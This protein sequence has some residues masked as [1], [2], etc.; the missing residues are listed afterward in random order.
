MT[1]SALT[2]M[3]GGGF[4]NRNSSLQE[5]AILE[6]L[7]LWRALVA[8]AP[9]KDDAFVIVDY[10]ASQGKNSLRPI[11]L[12]IDV[13]RNR[14]ESPKAIEVIHTDLPANDF[15][16]LFETLINDPD[17]YLRKGADIYP[18]A[19]GRSYFEPILAPDSAH[20]A[21]NSWSLQWTSVR[22]AEIRDHIFI[23]GSADAVARRA[24]ED[25]LAQDW[26]AFLQARAKELAPGG[27]LLTMFVAKDPSGAGW[28]PFWD[29]LW[30]VLQ[31][32]AGEGLL[33]SDV[34]AAISLPVGA[35]SL[36]DVKAP[37]DASGRFAELSVEHLEIL[38]GP[39]P[40]FDDF[41]R[42]G[43]AGTFG[44]KWANMARA[45]IAPIISGVFTRNATD[46]GLMDEAFRRFAA[47][48]AANP[49]RI[50]HHL[51]LVILR[52]DEV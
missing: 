49:F 14:P 27:R 21:W 17:S 11:N 33:T 16:S 26:N 13:L 52:K 45:V 35:R 24:F 19:V 2:A 32:M 15:S 29:L 18:S 44:E 20:L 37:F 5:A 22:P 6:V 36:D 7:P 31:E 41:Q 51:A 1:S 3:Q 10:A 48:M 43:D 9:I 50:K 34:L 4:Y 46:P 47:G 40:F 8:K 42:T 23:D 38:E 30:R 12:A 25:R 39:D 28:T